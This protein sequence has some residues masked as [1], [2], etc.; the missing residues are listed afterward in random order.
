MSKPQD[1][2]QIESLLDSAMRSVRPPDDVMQR[3]REKIGSIEP[4]IIAKRLSNWEFTI[5]LMG[6]VMA[7]AT[8]I[9]SIA[10][11]FFYFFNRSK[12]SA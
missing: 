3:L 2:T 10:R 9:L 11:A 1:T 12:R 7:V 6:S 8:I 5:I 4:T